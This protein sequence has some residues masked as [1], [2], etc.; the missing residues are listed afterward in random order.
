MLT[1]RTIIHVAPAIIVIVL[2][3]QQ[4]HLLISLIA[5]EGVILRLVLI[6]PPILCINSIS[7]AQVCIIILSLGA[8]EASLGLA[9]LVCA[10]RFTGSDI[11]K[12][13]STNKC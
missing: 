8:C 4:T 10:A 3:I 5:L 11:V 13:L 9:L 7:L 12:S 6:I 1:A 2:L